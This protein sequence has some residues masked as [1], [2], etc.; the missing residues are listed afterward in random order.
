MSENV[1]ELT[2]TIKDEE[3]TLKNKFLLYD[4]Y[5]VH[6]EDPIIKS[7]ISKSLEGFQ[8]VPT[9]VKIRINMVI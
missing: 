4:L 8:G 3:K 9:D 7:C 1:S 6:S 5:S 2:V